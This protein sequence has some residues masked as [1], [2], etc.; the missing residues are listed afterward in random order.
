MNGGNRAGA[1]VPPADLFVIGCGDE[2]VGVRAPDDGF[3]D[4]VVN[5][6]ADFVARS[7]EG[8]A[9][10][11][12][13]TSGGGRST[14]VAAGVGAGEVEDSQLLFIAA[15]GKELGIGL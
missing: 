2:D 13:G 12:V 14:A 9:V 15:G 10:H 6:R 3:D 8:G 11:A 7:E 5:A 4:I 1:D